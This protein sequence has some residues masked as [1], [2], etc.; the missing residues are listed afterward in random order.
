MEDLP[1]DVELADAVV[2]KG[3]ARDTIDARR[4]RRRLSGA[5][6]DFGPDIV[7]SDYSMP[8]FDGMSALNLAKAHRSAVALHRPHGLDE[9]GRRGGVH[10]G[11]G[12]RLRDQGA[13]GAP[14]FRRQ[15][16][17]RAPADRSIASRQSRGKAPGERGALPRPIRGKPRRDAHHRPAGQERI[18]EANQA[19]CD[20]YGWSRDELLGKKMTDITFMATSE[21]REEHRSRDRPEDLPFHIAGIGRRTER[22]STWRCYSGPIELQ[23]RTCLLY[24]NPRHLRSRRGR[25]RARRNL[26]SAQPLPLHEPHRDL[27]AAHKGGEGPDGSG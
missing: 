13:H 2:G 14:S 22:W 9:R 1:N 26:L 4:Y 20:F 3:R 15:G 23:G 24:H 10:E 25:A 18:V 21:I 17:P 7:I 27:L 6:T 11:R 5:L 12:E 19:A 16:G 8:S